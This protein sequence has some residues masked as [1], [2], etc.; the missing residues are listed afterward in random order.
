MLKSRPVSS[1]TTHQPG[2]YCY[3]PRTGQRLWLV[4][5][6]VERVNPFYSFLTPCLLFF[7]YHSAGNFQWAKIIKTLSLLWSTNK[8]NSLAEFVSAPYIHNLLF[9]CARL[10]QVRFYIEGK[11]TSITTDLPTILQ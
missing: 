3:Y 2:L 9:H 6:T 5:G 10:F 4:A 7:R 11:I 8:N 1:F